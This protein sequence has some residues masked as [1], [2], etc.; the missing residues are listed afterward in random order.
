[1]KCVLFMQQPFSV[2]H[3][4]VR[5]QVPIVDRISISRADQITDVVVRHKEAN[6]VQ[7]G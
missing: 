3:K 5:L 2:I 7:I 1:M 6:P 4:R